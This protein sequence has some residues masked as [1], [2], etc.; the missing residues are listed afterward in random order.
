MVP[1]KLSMCDIRKVSA[2]DKIIY[3]DL[4]SRGLLE[5]GCY[6]LP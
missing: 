2:V 5:T 4:F 1:K 6:S 3:L